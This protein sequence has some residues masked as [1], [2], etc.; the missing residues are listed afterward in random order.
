MTAPTDP[1]QSDDDYSLHGEDIPPL[2]SDEALEV[3]SLGG[4]IP[5]ILR[6]R[7]QKDEDEG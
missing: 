7:L 6:Q 1:P 3:L 4:E 5:D 2:D